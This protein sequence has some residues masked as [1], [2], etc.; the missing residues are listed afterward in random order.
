VPYLD[1]GNPLASKHEL[2]KTFAAEAFLSV[3]AELQGTSIIT[4]RTANNGDMFHDIHP[5]KKTAVHDVARNG[6]CP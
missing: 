5:A 4:Y 2:K 6:N 1:F 3:F